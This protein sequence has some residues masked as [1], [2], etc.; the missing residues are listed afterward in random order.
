MD[1]ANALDYYRRHQFISF[2]NPRDII[3]KNLRTSLPDVEALVIDPPNI[4][5]VEL[6]EGQYLVEDG[7]VEPYQAYQVHTGIDKIFDAVKGAG[8][9]FDQMAT[10][11]I[12]QCVE[13]RWEIMEAKYGSDKT[14]FRRYVPTPGR[15]APTLFPKTESGSYV[16]CRRWPP[17]SK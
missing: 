11:A 13:M 4:T 14:F 10:A 3:E 16:A 1:L 7:R 6:H 8:P 9:G 15:P 5:S 12:K 2:W 17:T